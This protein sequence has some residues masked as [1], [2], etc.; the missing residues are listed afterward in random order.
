M[1]PCRRRRRTA[2][3]GCR[4]SS[5]GTDLAADPLS[6]LPRDRAL[7]ELVAQSDLELGAVQARL[8]APGRGMKNSLRSLRSLSVT[9]TVTNEGE[10]KMKS[11]S[12]TCSSSLRSASKAKIEK[13]DAAMRTWSRG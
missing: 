12:P 7:G 10:V 2:A 5:T 9:L 3:S 6:A 11:S 4:S 1:Q 8:A 13:V